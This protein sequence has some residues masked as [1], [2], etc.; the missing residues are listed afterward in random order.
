MSTDV[1]YQ[2]MPDIVDCDIGGERAL[3]ELESNTYFTLNMTAAEIWVALSEPKTVDA[4]VGVVT[5]KFDVT[6]ATCRN[7]V[8]TVISQMLAAKIVTQ[9]TPAGAVK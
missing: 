8:E 1:Y 7:D 6:D 2:A 3:L 5:E 4:L 9:T